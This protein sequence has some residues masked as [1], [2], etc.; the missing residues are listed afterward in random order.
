MFNTNGGSFIETPKAL[1][2]V[3]A[4][5][6]VTE[7]TGPATVTLNDCYYLASAGAVATTK[8]T[9][10]TSTVVI[11]Y[12]GVETA[13]VKS[14]TAADLV[15][16]DAFKK[17]ATNLGWVVYEDKAI[18]ASVKCLE[19]GHDNTDV[20]VPPEGCGKQGYTEHTCK[21]CG[22]VTKDNFVQA[23]PH[24]YVDAVVAPTCTAKGYTEHKCSVCGDSYKDNE[25]DMVDHVMGMEWIV[26]REP[27]EEFSGLRYKAC[28]VC[29]KPLENE[30]I[31]ALTPAESE[32]EAAATETEAETE[33]AEE[34]GCGSSVALGSAFA[35]IT[36]MSLGAT[37][38]RKKER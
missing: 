3:N 7:P 12:D 31:P 35:I 33:T 38:L 32:T 30:V 21:V 24:E 25:V 26:D 36:M 37:V 29:G 1:G 20:V 17:T 27:D 14:A 2:T 9:D 6:I 18:P 13:N 16:L 19:A 11:K 5:G 34:G 23:E 8:A 10:A 4:D 15:A 22:T 28:T